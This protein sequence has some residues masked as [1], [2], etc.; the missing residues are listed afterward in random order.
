MRI[1]APVSLE[2]LQKAIHKLSVTKVHISTLFYNDHA[3][4][5]A[6]TDALHRSRTPSAGGSPS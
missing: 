5:I 6:E 4:K 3:G 2:L 1:N